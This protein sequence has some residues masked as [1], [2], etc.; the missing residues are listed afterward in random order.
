MIADN[1]VRPDDGAG[2]DHGIL[3]NDG[4]RMHCHPRASCSD[5]IGQKRH[6]ELGFGGNLIAD[7]RLRIGA[8]QARPAG[9]DRH[10]EA[11]TVTRYHGKA[12]LGVVDTAQVGPPRRRAL[13]THLSEKD[14]RDLGQGLNHEHAR[15]ERRSGKM[16]LEEFLVDGDVLDRNDPASG[17]VLEHRVNERRGVAIAEAFEDF[18]NVDGH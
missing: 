11:K 13:G 4:A 14:G 1:G 16:S 12:E 5:A 2:A 18:R 6:Q 9:T 17:L 10:L 3:V 7:V 15:H 8:S